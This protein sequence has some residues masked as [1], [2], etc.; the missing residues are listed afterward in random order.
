[1]KQLKLS[2][3]PSFRKNYLSPALEAKW[4]ERTQPDSPKSP[5]QGYRLTPKG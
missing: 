3:A 2:H 5:T 1:M 4:I